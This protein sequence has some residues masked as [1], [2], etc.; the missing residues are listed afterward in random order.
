MGDGVLR[1]WVGII[2]GLCEKLYLKCRLYQ[3][4]NHLDC[5]G[6]IV[7]DYQLISSCF[8]KHLSQEEKEQITGR[9]LTKIESLNEL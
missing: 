3:Q 8:C 1:S 2:K 4:A 5:W 9:I 7:E 6:I